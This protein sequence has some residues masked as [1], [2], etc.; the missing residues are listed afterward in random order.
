MKNSTKHA[1][2]LKPLLKKLDAGAAAGHAHDDDPVGVLIFS[3][4]LAGATVQQ[5]QVAYKALLDQ[6]VDFND[7]RVCMPHEIAALIG[8][9]YPDA[10]DHARRLRA[11]LRSV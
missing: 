3:S 4:L 11:A 7:L 10:D 6:V 9:N 8:K 5:A 1:T 2:K